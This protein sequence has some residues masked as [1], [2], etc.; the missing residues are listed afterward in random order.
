[1]T[2]VLDRHFDDDGLIIDLP[3]VFNVVDDLFYFLKKCLRAI[4][5]GLRTVN[6][7][8]IAELI[9]RIVRV[10]LCEVIDVHRFARFEHATDQ[11]G[12][13]SFTFSCRHS[14]ASLWIYQSS[15]Y[16]LSAA[17]NEPGTAKS[18]SLSWLYFSRA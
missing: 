8:K 1:M 10:E 16:F 7:G 11:L 2:V 17:R 15:A 4:D 3:D 12:V 5:D 18:V 9:V 6:D 13:C 14:C